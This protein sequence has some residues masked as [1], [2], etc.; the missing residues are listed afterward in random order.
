MQGIQDL[1]VNKTGGIPALPE[2][3]GWWGTSYHTH[4]DDGCYTGY[5][6]PTA[7]KL[8]LFRVSRKALVN[9][10]LKSTDC[11]SQM[12]MQRVMGGGGGEGNAVTQFLHNAPGYDVP[13]ETLWSK[14]FIQM[15]SLQTKAAATSSGNMQLSPFHLVSQQ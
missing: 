4:L 6:K 2:M 12:R 5:W 8:N 1:R 10:M 15:T 14:G 3:T 9:V 13:E 7:E 11:D